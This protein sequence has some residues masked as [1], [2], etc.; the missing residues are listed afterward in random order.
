[1]NYISAVQQRVDRF[2]PS[3]PV[4]PSHSA[5]K[6]K[7][8]NAM[9]DTRPLIILKSWNCNLPDFW[10]RFS[11]VPHGTVFDYAIVWYAAWWSP[12]LLAPD[13]QITNCLG[14][15][16]A[17][18]VGRFRGGQSGGG[19]YQLPDFRE[20]LSPVTWERVVPPLLVSWSR[21]VAIYFQSILRQN[22]LYHD[23]A[24]RGRGGAIVR[25]MC[26]QRWRSWTEFGEL[27]L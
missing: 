16:K 1:M 22:W 27:G 2:W 15:G 12:R 3:A 11:D 23:N 26:L 25:G 18:S 19:G 20:V 7:K 17:L 8:C 6:K 10:I 14:I 4:F 24:F 9:H 13:F 5:E 21:E